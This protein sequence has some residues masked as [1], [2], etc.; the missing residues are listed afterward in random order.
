MYRQIIKA[1]E[2]LVLFF[3]KNIDLFMSIDLF[4]IFILSKQ[5]TNHI[6]KVINA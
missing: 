1:M 6:V 4:Y 3:T 5:P 2:Q